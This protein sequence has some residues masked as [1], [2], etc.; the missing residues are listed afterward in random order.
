MTKTPGERIRPHGIYIHCSFHDLQA[1]NHLTM[2]PNPIEF[3]AVE[4]YKILSAGVDECWIVNSGSVKPHLHTL[5][6]LREMHGEI[7]LK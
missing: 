2:S 7:W 5:D 3:L 1:S 4:L 6:L